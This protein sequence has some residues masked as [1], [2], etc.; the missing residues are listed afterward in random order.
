MVGMILDEIDH[1]GKVTEPMAASRPCSSFEG[2]DY[3]DPSVWP[4]KMFPWDFVPAYA[5]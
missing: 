1:L 2:G 3:V 4:R 5:A